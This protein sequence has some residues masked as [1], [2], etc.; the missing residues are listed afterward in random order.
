MPR[1]AQFAIEFDHGVGR[2]TLRLHGE[3]DALSVPAFAATLVAIQ[4]R[5]NRFVTIDLSGLDFCNVGG[6]RAMAELAAHL[7]TRDGS[8]S[9][10]EPWI[11]TRMLDVA[12]L[13][14]LF[15]IEAEPGP[16]HGLPRGA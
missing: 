3:L 16:L 14:S 5:G 4:E 9:I 10:V 6:L 2:T 7:Q 13:R 1:P 12:D 11:L 8:V 15:A